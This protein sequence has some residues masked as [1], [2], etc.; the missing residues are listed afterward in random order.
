MDKVYEKWHK[1][2][3][4]KNKGALENIANENSRNPRNIQKMVDSAF[5]HVSPSC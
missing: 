2:A 5:L 3:H 1:I 4:A